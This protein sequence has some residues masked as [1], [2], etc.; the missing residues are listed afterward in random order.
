[1]NDQVI[2][3]VTKRNGGLEVTTAGTGN[4]QLAA[5]RVAA[6]ATFRVLAA[7]RRL[8]EEMATSV[9][10]SAVLDGIAEAGQSDC[11]MR[12]ISQDGPGK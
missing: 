10:A 12:E 1:M 6:A 7:A 3:R 9:I 11:G 2:L 5:M 8:P 4:D